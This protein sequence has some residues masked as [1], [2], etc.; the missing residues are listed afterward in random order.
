MLFKSALL[1]LI[2]WMVGGLA[3][4]GDMTNVAL[5]V[6]LLLLLLAFLKSRDNAARHRPNDAERKP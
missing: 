6:G 3:G 2:V 5:L 1:L 4:F